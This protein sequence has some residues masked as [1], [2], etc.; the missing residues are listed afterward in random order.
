MNPIT[1]VRILFNCRDDVG[2]KI[3]R[4]R[5]RKLDARQAGGSDSTQETTERRRAGESLETVFDARPVAIH[6]LTDQMNFFVAKRLQPFRFRDNLH[7]RTAA[8]AAT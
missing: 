8:F 1:Q 7:R 2:M 6:V 3:T 4:E 5:G